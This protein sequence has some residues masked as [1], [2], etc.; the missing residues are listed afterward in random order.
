MDGVRNYMV[1][2]SSGVE[3]EL[4]SRANQR[5]LR[6]FGH[7]ARMA[8]RALMTDVS[9]GRVWGRPRLGWVDGMKKVFGSRG[10][11]VDAAQQCTKDRKEWRALVH[12]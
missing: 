10:M 11:T 5:M 1:R 7:V 9:G 8:R 2:W 6:W 4:A 12:M 3:R